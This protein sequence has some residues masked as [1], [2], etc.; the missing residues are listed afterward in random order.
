MQT[1]VNETSEAVRRRGVTL[2]E[3]LVVVTLMGILSSVV[4]SRYG[5]DVFGDFGARS[6]AQHLW[7]D[8]EAAR[9]M[10]IRSGSEYSL[11]MTGTGT[12][13]WTGY[14]IVSGAPL[15]ARGGKG[16]SQTGAP[17]VFPAELVV[18]GGVKVVGFSFE[19]HAS[20]A[21]EWT[22]TGPNRT[23]RVRLVPL[24][25]AASVSEVPR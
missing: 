2:L 23:W 10:A 3:L 1:S 19:G 7:I 17:R 21:A 12:G 24:S 4:V 20:E 5:R 25:G 6:E 18:S 11:I 9:R 16:V 13:P 8:L 22:L 14:D 15:D